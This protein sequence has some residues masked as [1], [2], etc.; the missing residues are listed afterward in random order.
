MSQARNRFDPTIQMILN[1]TDDGT[2]IST[3][4]IEVSSDMTVTIEGV[5]N[6]YT[7]AAGTLGESKSWT[8]TA[9]A[10]RTIY[11]KSQ[12]GTSIVFIPFPDRIISI[13]RVGGEATNNGWNSTVTHILSF[14]F[15]KLVN[16]TSLRT[17]GA[18]TIV[19]SMPM[20]LIYF[21]ISSNNVNYLNADQASLS[22]TFFNL[23]GNSIDWTG[24]NVDGKNN[25]TALNLTNHRISK[26]DDEQLLTLLDTMIARTGGLPATCSI[27][28]YLNWNN[29]PQ[30][31]TD[32]I[33][34]LKA[35][36]PNITVVNLTV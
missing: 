3:L 26:M 4:R 36:K 1:S 20:S 12:A 7:N 14:S 18:A 31:V 22:L 25:M 28:D 15:V 27:G 16:L 32:K 13:G 11:I 21:N 2:R 6:F 9:G 29:V 23:I 24:L 30:S 35:A 8:I 10:L 5:A 33:A 17:T 34:E 19:G